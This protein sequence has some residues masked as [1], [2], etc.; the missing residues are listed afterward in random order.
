ML[1]TDHIPLIN[2]FRDSRGRGPAKVAPSMCVHSQLSRFSIR[3]HPPCA[4]IHSFHV[5]LLG[6]SGS[7][8]SCLVGYLYM[9]LAPFGFG[10][11]I[12][13]CNSAQSSIVAGLTF[14]LQV[15]PKC[16]RT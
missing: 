6:S 4:C 15:G 3:W 5:S 1:V 7:V 11:R 13:S 10:P 2:C 16:L 12:K 14:P 9:G 8:P